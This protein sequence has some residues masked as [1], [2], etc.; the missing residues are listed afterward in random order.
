MV[1]M[2]HATVLEEPPCV[3]VNHC[4]H[5]AR[6]IPDESTYDIENVVTPGNR[7]SNGV[8]SRSFPHLPYED[9]S[10]RPIRLPVLKLFCIR[11]LSKECVKFVRKKADTEKLL[12]D[13]CIRLC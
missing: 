13:S 1:M 8:D 12:E 9:L 3:G 6:Y 2:K 4:Q 10:Q 7:V 11:E 5:R